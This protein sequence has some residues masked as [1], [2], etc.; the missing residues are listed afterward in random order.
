M[1]LVLR[2]AAR[3]DRG[4]VRAKNEDCIGHCPELGLV[5]LA[6]GMGGHAGGEVASALAVNTILD[7]LKVRIPELRAGQQRS[8]D[9]ETL[10]VQESINQANTVIYQAAQRHPHCAGMGTTLVLGLLHGARLTIAHVGDSRMYRFRA[11]KL[12]QL[13]VDHTLLQALI[14]HEIYA[15]QDAQAL[16]YK[17]RVTRALGPDATVT[18]EVCEVE[19]VDEDIYLLCS[20]GLND[21]VEDRVIEA[22]LQHTGDD[23]EQAVEQLIW[24]ANHQGGRDNVSV[25]LIRPVV[26]APS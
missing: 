18:P 1:D 6:D 16:I 8:P 3:T 19:V 14:D 22:T 9:C 10:A 11:G 26:A 17:N 21:M 23:L 4:Q 15:R 13:T 2:I 20:D 5:V 12:S 24:L 7:R 25:I